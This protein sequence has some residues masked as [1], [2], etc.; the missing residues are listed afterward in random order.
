MRTNQIM[1]LANQP[2]CDWWG[3]QGRWVEEPNRDRGGFSGVQVLEAG[4]GRRFF[5]K[6]QANYLFRSVRYPLGRPTLLREFRNF[7]TYERLG[8]ATPDVVCFDM[9]QRDG[10]WEALLVTRA[11]EGFIS[12]RDG[13]RAKRWGAARRAAVLDAV[14]TEITSLHGMARKHGHLY[15]KEI[16]IDDREDEIHV[17]LLDLELSRRCLS[18][19]QAA[20]SD[21]KRFLKGMFELGMSPGEYQRLL[22]RY[23]QAGIDLPA[24]VRE[25]GAYY[26]ADTKRC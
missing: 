19:G 3:S 10:R 16:F 1:P 25:L 4:D 21:L 26:L 14:L 6:R 20:A 9:R 15:P 24:R 13:L 8:F 12:L 5:I 2:S 22:D 18:A 23:A 11:L 17:A 7:R